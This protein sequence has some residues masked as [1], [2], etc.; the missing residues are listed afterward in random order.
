METLD[1]KN[2]HYVVNLEDSWKNINPW[3]GKA[4]NENIIPTDVNDI[5]KSKCFSTFKI[6]YKVLNEE[7]SQ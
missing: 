6:Y 4:N 5:S 7:F 1:K 2:K 3:H